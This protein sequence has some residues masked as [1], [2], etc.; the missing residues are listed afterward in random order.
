MYFT[1]ESLVWPGDLKS[2][3]LLLVD[4]GKS[5]TP[6]VHEDHEPQVQPTEGPFGLII[7]PSREL[8]HQTYEALTKAE[9]LWTV[10][11]FKE[12]LVKADIAGN[13]PRMEKKHPKPEQ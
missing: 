6:F 10:W 8:A 3:G 4:V 9:E 5:E 13:P 1:Y 11:Q 2:L 7:A 12:S